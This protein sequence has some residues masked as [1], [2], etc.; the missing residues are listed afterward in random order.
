MKKTFLIVSISENRRGLIAEVA[1]AL[2]THAISAH[3]CHHG[4]IGHCHGADAKPPAV[5]VKPP[6]KNTCIPR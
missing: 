3:N 4:A 6:A 5:R 2:L 1:H